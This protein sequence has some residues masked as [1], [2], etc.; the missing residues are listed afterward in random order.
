MYN[1]RNRGLKR[2]VLLIKPVVTSWII[3]IKKIFRRLRH[4][5]KDN[6]KIDLKRDL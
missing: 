3:F 2:A 5:R 4:R 6:I 1:C